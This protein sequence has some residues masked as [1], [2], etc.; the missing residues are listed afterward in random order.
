[1]AQAR[2]KKPCTAAKAEEPLCDCAVRPCEQLK[3]DGHSGL[4]GL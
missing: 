1:M 3:A 4:H 2:G